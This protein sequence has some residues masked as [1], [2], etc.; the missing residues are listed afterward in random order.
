MAGDVT[1]NKH[2]LCDITLSSK[3]KQQMQKR[4]QWKKMASIFIL[5]KSVS[6]VFVRFI[7][8]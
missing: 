7:V 6:A 8:H 4:R 2:L 5:S 1:G 3:Q